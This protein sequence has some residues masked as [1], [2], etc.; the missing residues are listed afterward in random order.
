MW[1][2]RPGHVRPNPVLP[3]T[4]THPSIPLQCLQTHASEKGASITPGEPSVPAGPPRSLPRGLQLL[5]LVLLRCGCPPPAAPWLASYESRPAS[6]L[7]Q[8]IPVHSS[9]GSSSVSIVVPWSV[10]LLLLLRLLWRAPLLACG[11]W[12]GEIDRKGKCKMGRRQAGRVDLLACNESNRIGTRS[13]RCIDRT[14]RL[15]GLARSRSGVIHSTD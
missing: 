3:T 11:V 15:A 13:D 6:F 14:A 5:L 1:V 10:L 12:G 4:T 8:T 2:D 7:L 9:S